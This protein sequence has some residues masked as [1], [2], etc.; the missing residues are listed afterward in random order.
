MRSSCRRSDGIGSSCREVI[1]TKVALAVAILG[2]SFVAC[3]GDRGPDTTSS[4]STPQSTTACPLA[5]PCP[6]GSALNPATCQCAPAADAG[7]CVSGE[8]GPCGGFTTHPCR[9]AHRLV[10]VPNR[11]PDLPGTCERR[12][13]ID[14]GDRDDHDGAAP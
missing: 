8:D 13:D 4:T 1:M 12:R 11:I 3:A 14:G 2:S 5:V 6:E 10:C 9:C 7:A